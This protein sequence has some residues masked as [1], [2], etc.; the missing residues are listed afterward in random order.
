M[1]IT[2]NGEAAI[3][4]PVTGNPT[5]SRSPRKRWRKIEI[6]FRNP[7]HADLFPQCRF[8]SSAS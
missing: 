4:G 1:H 5:V 3:I 2:S 8:K 7:L 6:H